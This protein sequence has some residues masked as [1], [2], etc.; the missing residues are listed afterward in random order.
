[1]SL[2]NSIQSMLPRP[3]SRSRDQIARDLDD[4]FN[5]HLEMKAR[6]LQSEEGLD[7]DAACGLARD[8]FG[9][10]ERIR[11][12]CQRIALRERIMLQR[13]NLVL[14]IVVMLVVIA[15]GAQVYI[16]QR[17]NTLALQAIT[18]DLA[19]MKFDAEAATRANP[20]PRVVYIDGDLP[21]PG[22]YAL[23]TAGKLTL[24]RVL[25]AA[26]AAETGEVVSV[27]VNGSDPDGRSIVRYI[28]E[29]YSLTRDPNSDLVLSP[30]D[31]IVVTA[32][33]SNT[34]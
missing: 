31:R 8:C 33:D 19:R 30:N 26:G 5:F 21:R 9:D 32:V 13:V 4:E 6:A 12:D 14:M 24:S 25:T 11:K 27:L 15:V 28:D 20:A 10:I 2:I 1:M 22:V 29:H 3:E 18:A 16:T 34:T 17:Y 23:P 7:R